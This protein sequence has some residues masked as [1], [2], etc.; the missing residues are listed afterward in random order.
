MAKYEEKFKPNDLKLRDVD[1]LKFWQ[2][3]VS[4]CHFGSSMRDCVRG[5]YGYTK[6]GDNLFCDGLNMKDD[7]DLKASIEALRRYADFDYEYSLK[8]HLRKQL[9]IYYDERVKEQ[10]WGTKKSAKDA[11]EGLKGEK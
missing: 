8:D 11:K 6:E 4:C 1:G 5:D 7:I 3:V 10:V 2:L 9:A